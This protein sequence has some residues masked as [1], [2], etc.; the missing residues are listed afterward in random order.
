V[1]FYREG[2]W[3]RKPEAGKWVSASSLKGGG[4]REAISKKGEI[5]IERNPCE[6]IVREGSR[7]GLG[8]ERIA[9]T[10]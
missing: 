5:N 6:G 7:G 8:I 9:P 3:E 4:E 10:L 2:I 1:T